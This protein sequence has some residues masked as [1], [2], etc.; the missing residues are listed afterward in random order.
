MAYMPAERHRRILDMLERDGRVR[1]R[2]LRGEFG[3]TAMS[4]WRDLR[5]ME[6]LGLLRRIRGG[7]VARELEPEPDFAE[8]EA[9]AAEAKRQIARH[10]VA[11][12]MAEG[13]MIILDGG[14]TVA[15]LADC[16]LPRRLTVLTNSLPVAERLMRHPARPIVRVSGGLL[17]PE[18]GTLVGQEALHFFHRRRASRPLA[19]RLFLSASAIDEEAGVTD[20]NTKEIEV[21]QA[22]ASAARE[23]ILLADDSKFG[24]VS[25]MPTLPWRRIDRLIMNGS[26]SDAKWSGIRERLSVEFV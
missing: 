16:D 23:V 13:D 3:M 20:P 21:K 9:R 14:T 26:P 15:A 5:D 6:A 10:A 4:V 11:R 24:R 12:H 7:A 8:K 25:H 17:R 19:S 1:S 2:D 22:M 18:S